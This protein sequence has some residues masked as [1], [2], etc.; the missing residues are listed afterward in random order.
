MIMLKYPDFQS[1]NI[2]EISSFDSLTS[3][4]YLEGL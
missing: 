2:N 1:I 3:A 4:R